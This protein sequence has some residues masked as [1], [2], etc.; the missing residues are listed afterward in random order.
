MRRSM[1]GILCSLSTLVAHF[2]RVCYRT[3]ARGRLAKEN[4]CG[5]VSTR[6]PALSAALQRG[7]E[8]LSS[9][10]VARGTSL[11]CDGRLPIDLARSEGFRVESSDGYVGVVDTLR[12]APSSRWDRPSELAV[13]A[14]RRTETLLIIP[15]AE[16]E[17]V[18]L[19]ERRVVLRPSTRIAATERA[20]ARPSPRTVK[21]A[22]CRR[23]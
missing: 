18:S 5:D 17:G 15:L 8:E 22:Q 16:V 20:S 12:Y 4:F 7:P 13:F 21:G 6:R 10:Q 9:N 2:L 3:H 14:G 23:A 11:E 1:R 19:A